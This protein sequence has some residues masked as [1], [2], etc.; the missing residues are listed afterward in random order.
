[1]KKINLILK[2]RKDSEKE[3]N[4]DAWLPH[5]TSKLAV[6]R[7]LNGG[8]SVTHVRSG[9]AVRQDLKHK[10]QALELATA[11]GEH[12]E[13]DPVGPRGGIQDVP[14]EFG[15]AIMT[16]AFR[17]KIKGYERGSISSEFNARYKSLITF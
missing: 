17:I 2:L 3:S 4:V 15:I 5:S 16:A 13:W 10:W 11:F 8:W 6:H 14:K 9:I 12:D 1:M 7:G